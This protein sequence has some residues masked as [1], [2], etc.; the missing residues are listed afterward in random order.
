MKLTNLAPLFALLIWIGAPS[1]ARAGEV[2]NETSFVVEVAKAWRTPEGLNVEG[3]TRILPGGC[4]EIGPESD[5]EQYIYA[6]ST[7][8]YLG[9][10]REWRGSQIACVDQTDFEIQGVGECEA[11][12]LQERRFRRLSESERE[13]TVLAEVADFGSR[14]QEAGLQ[15]LLQSAGYDIRTIDGYAGRRTRQQIAAFQNDVDTNYGSDRIGLL[16]AL[17]ERALARNSNAGLQICNNARAPMAAA[18]ARATGDGYEARGWWRVEPGNCARPLAM[19]LTD[20]EV[21]VHARLL[22][23]AEERILADSDEVFCV[24]AG[25]FTTDRREGCGSTGFQSARF[26][27]VMSVSDGTARLSFQDEDFGEALR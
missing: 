11:L 12:G 10:V 24:G 8:A 15:R 21:F 18:V 22:D 16:Q 3:W 2:C 5:I 7:A 19:R 1:I 13:R 27:P 14:A 6:R 26:R 4:A 9:G 23:G 20:G 17:H 25:R